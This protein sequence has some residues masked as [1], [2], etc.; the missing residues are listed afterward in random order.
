MSTGHAKCQLIW[1]FHNSFVCTASL[2]PT[3][4][5]KFNDP[6]N[7][8]YSGYFTISFL[9]TVSLIPT[10]MSDGHDNVS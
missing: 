4:M 3:E 9:C 7:V 5:S 10:E 2:I 6:G 1:T 8:R